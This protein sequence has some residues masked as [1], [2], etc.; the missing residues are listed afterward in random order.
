VDD[1]L[2]EQILQKIGG[3]S[4]SD[5]SIWRRAQ[6]WGEQIRVAEQARATA[7]AGLPQRG[8]II[9]GT[10]P[11]ERPMGT[12]LDGGRIHLCDEGGKELKVGTVFDIESRLE[13]NPITREEEPQAHAGDTSCVAVWGGRWG[14]KRCGEAFPRRGIESRWAMG[15]LDL[16]CDG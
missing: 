1:D 15:P 14:R 3:G 11:H 6:Q 5:T 7:A 16:E 9:G 13:R 10:V 4:I 2:A 8:E 12:A